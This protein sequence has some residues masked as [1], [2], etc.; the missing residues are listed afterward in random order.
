M[1]VTPLIP[2][3]GPCPDSHSSFA[4]YARRG[5]VRP[6]RTQ[7]RTRNLQPGR[8][9]CCMRNARRLI[10]IPP[11]PVI[12][13]SPLAEQVDYSACHR[14]QS[15]QPPNDSA[16]H[17]LACNAMQTPTGSRMTACLASVDPLMISPPPSRTSRRLSSKSSTGRLSIQTGG[18]PALSPPAWQ[19]SPADTPS[20]RRI[21]NP[22]WTSAEAVDHPTTCY[23]AAALPGTR[24]II[25]SAITVAG[26]ATRIAARRLTHLRISCGRPTG[27][28]HRQPS[29]PG[30]LPSAH[31]N[32]FLIKRTAPPQLHAPVRRRDD[33]AIPRT[34]PRA[35]V[36]VG[37]P[38]HAA[39]GLRSRRSGTESGSTHAR[40]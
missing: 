33:F 26:H 31:I 20:G 6:A 40:F 27:H 17:S 9:G 3:P 39:P 24:P 38:Q 23:W 4:Q 36:A 32:D 37:L 30:C 2:T 12:I 18:I 28:G 34:H 11:M 10:T 8:A 5:R 13:Q 35:P 22:A 7:P 25:A 15:R 14:G 19:I 29:V 1:T 21:S 16:H